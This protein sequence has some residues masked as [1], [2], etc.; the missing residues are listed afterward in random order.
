MRTYCV[1]GCGRS[2]ADPGRAGAAWKCSHCSA[3]RYASSRRD[4]TRVS[5]LEIQAL[6]R[7]FNGDLMDAAESIK[8]DLTEFRQR[9]E[10]IR[11]IRKEMP[12]SASAPAPP[13]AP[14]PAPA[15]DTIVAAVDAAAVAVAAEKRQEKRAA[16]RVEPPPPRTTTIK[17]PEAPVGRGWKRGEKLRVSSDAYVLAVYQRT[18][19]VKRAAE[20]FGCYSRTLTM[21]L[22]RMGVPLGKNSK[23]N[24]RIA[25]GLLRHYENSRTDEDVADK[26]RIHLASRE[27]VLEAYHRLGTAVAVGREFNCLTQTACRRLNREGVD[28]G[29]N[30]GRRGGVLGQSEDPRWLDDKAVEAACWRL[31]TVTNV[32]AEFG[33]SFYTARKRMLAL[34]FNN[35]RCNSGRRVRVFG[36]F[37]EKDGRLKIAGEQPRQVRVADKWSEKTALLAMSVMG[38]HPGKCDGGEFRLVEHGKRLVCGRVFTGDVDFAIVNHPVVQWTKDISMATTIP[39]PL[40]LR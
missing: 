34:G 37:L 18:K 33:V 1:D 7:K 39:T 4:L 40:E 32:A 13:P 19:N 30:R 23:S 3:A 14:A 20:V 29:G 35:L 27:E 22:K 31:V 2:V 25:A 38:V 16:Q 15:P 17:G 11:G 9:W 26:M 21:R 36:H 5:D 12:K 10:V 6:V 24:S 28:L 8:V